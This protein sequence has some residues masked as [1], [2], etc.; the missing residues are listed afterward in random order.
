[1]HDQQD[2]NHPRILLEAAWKHSR[3]PI[4]AVDCET[5]LIAGVNPAAERLTGFSRAQLIG[6][7]YSELQPEDERHALQEAFQH[8]ESR[9]SF[10]TG[11]HLLSNHDCPALVEISLSEPFEVEGRT[12]MLATERDMGRLQDREQQLA[13]REWALKAYAGAALALARAR[14]TTGLMQQ[15]CEAITHESPFLLAW[16]GFAEDGPGKPVRMIGA[17]GKALP[18]L[19][20]LEVSWDENRPAGQGPTGVSVRTGTVQ[21]MEDAEHDESFKLWRER[22]RQQGIRASIT[23]PVFAAGRRGVMVVYSSHART[24]GPVVAEAFT[25]LA[26]EIGSGLHTLDQAERLETERQQREKAQQELTEA[27]AGLVGA[28]T[29]A[30]ELRDFYTAGHQRRVAELATAIARQMGWSDDHVEALRLAALVH[31]VGKIA[32]PAEILTKPTR[33]SPPEWALIQTHAEKGYEIL[34]DVPFRWPI[35][36]LVY[37]H[38]ERLDGSGYPRGLAGDAILMGA[39]ILAVADMVESMATARPYRM[40]QGMD[41]ALREIESLAG[42]N[43]DAEVVRTCLALFREQGFTFNKH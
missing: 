33:L 38:H 19:D 31:D 37:Q 12:L 6:K 26:E 41:A 27:F 39:R 34:K 22:A 14:S 42:S 7:H 29:T 9:S 35:A 21:I 2:S 11:F 8:A 15:I 18:Y 16:G 1:M 3:D 10:I 32:V 17:A 43:L 20:G 4:F 30:V 23:V 25:H 40:A 5:G 13:I 28:I 24:F 36:E